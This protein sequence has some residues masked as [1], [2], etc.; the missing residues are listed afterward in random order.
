VFPWGIPYAGAKG[1]IHPCTG[2][3]SERKA[4][5]RPLFPR[6]ETRHRSDQKSL[7]NG[8]FGEDHCCNLPIL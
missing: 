8:D 7:L 2:F 1:G 3:F 6:T 4:I 5:R